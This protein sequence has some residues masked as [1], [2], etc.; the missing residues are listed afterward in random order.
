[1]D[2]GRVKLPEA[3]GTKWEKCNYRGLKAEACSYTPP[4]WSVSG[5]STAM[6]GMQWE[7]KDW[8]TGG[9]QINMV[10][11]IQGKLEKSS[12]THIL[13]SRAHP[14][15]ECFLEPWEKKREKQKADREAEEEEK[16]GQGGLFRE[17]ITSEV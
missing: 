6:S 16:L 1:M 5:S 2:A 8:Y 13:L 14:E 12:I 10:A 4:P 15:K 7:R 3:E 17:S 9:G 11:K